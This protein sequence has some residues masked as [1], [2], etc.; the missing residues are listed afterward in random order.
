V[1]KHHDK[2]DDPHL[3]EKY[4]KKGD[5]K[6]LSAFLR[7]VSDSRP[8]FLKVLQREKSNKKKQNRKTLF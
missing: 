8:L 2:S 3:K 6:T 1:I 4:R 7:N 5:E